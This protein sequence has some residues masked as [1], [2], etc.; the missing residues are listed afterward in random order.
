MTQAE[1]IK[2]VLADR[3]S[4]VEAYMQA[5]NVQATLKTHGWRIIESLLDDALNCVISDALVPSPTL[6]AAAAKTC[7]AQGAR[8]LVET[9]KVA[10]KSVA[11]VENP[12]PNA[13]PELVGLASEESNEQPES[14]D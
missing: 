13:E 7:Q 1:L 14:A 9:F 11:S 10:I 5:L 4:Q 6:D 8:L 12:N 3:E 2:A